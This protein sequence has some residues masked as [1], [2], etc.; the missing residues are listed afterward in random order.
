MYHTQL[1]NDYK[2]YNYIGISDVKG[3]QLELVNPE[4]E[5]VEVNR[6]QIASNCKA[7][8]YNKKSETTTSYNV[9]AETGSNTTSLEDINN[10][11]RV[12]NLGRIS[13]NTI[14][15]ENEVMLNIELEER[16]LALLERQVKFRKEMV[17][18]ETIEL[19][20]RI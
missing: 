15:N 14:N 17:E 18:A 10:E 5:Q 20:N 2:N 3:F 1:R 6:Q 9:L 7:A 8:N 11:I 4:L 19:Q 12:E 13:I 16:K